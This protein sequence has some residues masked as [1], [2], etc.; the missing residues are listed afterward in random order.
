MPYL[1]VRYAVFLGLL[2]GTVTWLVAR[3]FSTPKDAAW[4][5]FWVALIAIIVFYFTSPT[6]D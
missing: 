1:A 2:I 5:G 6:I 4:L 3:K